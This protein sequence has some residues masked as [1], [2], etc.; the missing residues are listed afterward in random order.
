MAATIFSTPGTHQPLFYKDTNG[1]RELVADDGQS[2]PVTDGYP[3]LTFPRRPEERAATFRQFFND[4]SD[5]YDQFL[6]QTFKTHGEDETVT[7]NYMIDRLN[8]KPDS[9]VLEVACG[10]GRDSELIAQRLGSGSEY[11]L[12]DIA[13]AMLRRCEQRLQQF[14]IAKFFCVGSSGYLPF[15]DGYFDAVYCFAAM[16]Y[17]PDPGRSLAEMTRVTKKGGKVVIADESMPV[18]LRDTY[19]SKVLANSN[20]KVLED[21]PLKYIPVNARKV[22]IQWVIGGIFYLIDFEVGEGE[23][24]GDFDYEIAGPVR[25]GTLR[26][27]YEGQL[28]G[29]TPETKSMVYK[30][31]KA[32]GITVHKWLEQLVREAAEKDL[33]K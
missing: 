20:P 12:L 24:T 15:P 4:T 3:D 10:T 16:W 19:F 26:T 21:L 13:P 14:D 2:Y 31:A 11:A 29:V 18:W 27:R 6:G 23:P 9:K 30:A 28:E 17:F 32:R 7:R 25:G 33:G 1:S 5:I 8:L 22:N